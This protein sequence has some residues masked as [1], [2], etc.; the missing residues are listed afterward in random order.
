MSHSKLLVILAGGMTPTDLSD[1]SGASRRSDVPLGKKSVIEAVCEKA[2]DFFPDFA[3]V[4]AADKSS[5]PRNSMFL[6]RD[7]SLGL[8]EFPG[9]SPGAS[10]TLRFAL[11]HYEDPAQLVVLYADTLFIGERQIYWP[12]DFVGVGTAA[13]REDWGFVETAPDGAIAFLST[14]EGKSGPVTSGD[15]IC[16]IFGFSNVSLLKK[17]LTHSGLLTRDFLEAV[18]SYSRQLGDKL[19]LVHVEGWLDLGHHESYQSARKTLISGRFFNELEVKR[20]WVT[21]KCAST[22]KAKAE[23]EWFESVPLELEYMVPRT[24]PSKV[25]RTYEVEYIDAPSLGERASISSISVEEASWVTDQLTTWLKTTENGKSVSE[26]TTTKFLDFLRSKFNRRVHA[27]LTNE[28][29]SKL[30]FCADGYDFAANNLALIDV[31]DYVPKLH[32][33][34]ESFLHGD[35]YFGNILS[36]APKKTFKLIDPR[37][38]LGTPNMQGSQI[39]EWAKIGQ[40]LFLDFD[41]IE[42]GAFTHFQD[43]DKVWISFDKELASE[44]LFLMRQW[45]LDT[46]P[47]PVD[48][49]NLSALQLIA[50]SPLHLNEGN[51]YRAL[52]AKGYPALFGKAGL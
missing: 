32:I 43:R 12:K 42:R 8:L 17:H 4:V 31:A 28:N 23:L 3:I 6:K 11:D 13:T 15:A 5:I 33:F 37:G 2:K 20:G 44:G 52:I 22:E 29:F 35:L 48:A 38:A 27:L 50:S 34:P 49:L 9:E 45:F 39:Y 7:P 21:K 47:S 30:S 14:L 25:P 18:E 24:R 19:E 51:S 10:A 40:S 46:C 41:S 16:G 36:T 26:A 1:F